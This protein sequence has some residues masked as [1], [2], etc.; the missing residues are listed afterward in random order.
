MDLGQITVVDALQQTRMHA[1]HLVTDVLGS[2]AP[3]L[4]GQ[5]IVALDHVTGLDFQNQKLP[6][7]RDDDKVVFTKALLIALHA[8]P[9]H[10][11]KHIKT[12][13]K[14]LLQQPEDVAFTVTAQGGGGVQ[15]K[16]GVNTGHG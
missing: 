8:R 9:G 1:P 13:V 15:R 12:I 5:A 2:L 3:I 4:L 10:V 16:A 14:A 7:R 11:V 6:A